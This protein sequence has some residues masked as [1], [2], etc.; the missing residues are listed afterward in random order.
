M[1]GAGVVVAKLRDLA[2]Y[3]LIGLL[4]PVASAGLRTGE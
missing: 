1:G 3:A 2:P 4:M